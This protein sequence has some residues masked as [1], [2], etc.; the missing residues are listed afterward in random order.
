MKLLCFIKNLKTKI[1]AIVVGTVATLLF[2]QTTN[3]VH[4]Y[5]PQLL[6]FLW[7][8]RVTPFLPSTVW[9]YFSEY[10]IFLFAFLQLKDNR[11]ASQYFYSYMAI[12]IFSSVFFVIYPVTFPRDNYP[13]LSEHG[14]SGVALN[15]LRQHLDTPANCF[16]SLHVSTCYISAFC[17]WGECKKKFSLYFLWSTLVAISTMTTKQHYFVDIAAAIFITFVLYW[18]FFYKVSYRNFYASNGSGNSGAA[19]L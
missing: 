2:Y 16:P 7:I 6:S 3:R 19:I 12:L 11:R 8:D 14:F 15:F 17:F 9:I 13:V 5:E 18:I 4:L 1:F 10:V